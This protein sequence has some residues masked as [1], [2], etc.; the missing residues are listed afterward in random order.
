MRIFNKIKFRWFLKYMIAHTIYLKRGM[1]YKAH[2][3]LNIIECVKS[4]HQNS[5][6]LTYFWQ[7]GVFLDLPICVLG[8]VS[9]L[10][11]IERK[12]LT[13]WGYWKILWPICM[14]GINIIIFHAEL[15]IPKICKSIM[16]CVIFTVP[17]CNKDA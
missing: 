11:Y 13:V 6:Q 14:Q 16:G 9:F 4:I 15:T 17:L 2:Y 8:N 12:H 1:S 3:L 10:W 5:K 7:C